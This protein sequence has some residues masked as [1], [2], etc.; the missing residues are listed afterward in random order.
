MEYSNNYNVYRQYFTATQKYAS[1]W[2][3]LVSP[4]QRLDMLADIM[5][6]ELART[7]NQDKTYRR[8]DVIMFFPHGYKHDEE[9]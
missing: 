8:A 7:E 3:S 2:F 9:I 4:A 5:Q 6:M 1:R